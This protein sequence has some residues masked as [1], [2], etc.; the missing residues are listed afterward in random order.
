MDGRSKGRDVGLVD[1]E[2]SSSGG[3]CVGGLLSHFRCESKMRVRLR[4]R[5]GPVNQA[6]T[7]NDWKARGCRGHVTAAN[8]STSS[9]HHVFGIMTLGSV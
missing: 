5:T 6:G 8:K 1:R 7:V 2:V 4:W 9:F 3:V